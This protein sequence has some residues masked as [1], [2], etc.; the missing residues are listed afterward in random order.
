MI[1]TLRRMVGRHASLASPVA[2]LVA[3]LVLSFG[4]A[5]ASPA[6]AEPSRLCEGCGPPTVI[7]GQTLYPPVGPGDRAEYFSEPGFLSGD[8]ASLLINADVAALP[9][10]TAELPA[11]CA[12]GGATTVT[13]SSDPDPATPPKAVHY[14]IDGG[15]E[16]TLATTGNP[17]KATITVPTGSHTLEYWG[18]DGAG[19]LEASHHTAS[20]LIVPCPAPLAPVVPAPAVAPRITLVRLSPPAFAPPATVPAS[21]ASDCRRSGRPSATRTPRLPA[22][23]SPS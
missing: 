6:Q 2:A 1:A 15:S 16:Q 23:P 4:L 7:C 13:V 22:P 19:G 12:A 14:R 9:T 8:T 10:S 17:G 21:H 20:L 3:F 11:C 5:A 18:E